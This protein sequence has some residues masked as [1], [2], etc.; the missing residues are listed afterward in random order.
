V[1][2]ALLDLPAGQAGEAADRLVDAHLLEVAGRDGGGQVRYRL[3]G[4]VRLYA[5]ECAAAA[6]PPRARRAALARALGG[7][8]ALAERADAALGTPLLEPV[9]GQAARWPAGPAAT[10]AVLAGPLA[11]LEADPLAW[12]EAERPALAAAVT[13]AAAAGLAGLAWEL[14]SAL[15]Q[16]LAARGHLGDWRRATAAALAAARR[17][18]DA[19]GQA[20]V[21]VSAGARHALCGRPGQA[22]R[23]WQAAL[24]IFGR[25][26]DPTGQAMCLVGL[27]LCPPSGHAS[28]DK[29]CQ[30]AQDALALL[31]HGGGS[32][33]ARS[34][35]L[36]CLSLLHHQHG[37]PDLAQA[38]LEEALAVSCAPGS[39]HGQARQL[40]QLGAVPI[41]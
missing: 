9:Y 28:Y 41:P 13:Q 38:C 35:V 4:L 1:A 23:C 31:D 7:W 36:H 19:R 16:F 11:W 20:A 25:L 37:R 30:Q 21:L 12:L 27:A 3:P 39:R 2:A 22:A 24:A 29:R 18:R 8:L 33:R 34:C 26:A 14:T 32:P 15:T 6:G 10:G 5:R 40:S 17:A